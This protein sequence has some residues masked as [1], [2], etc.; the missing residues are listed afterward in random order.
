[1][2]T[3]FDFNENE[4]LNKADVSSSAFDF[5]TNFI[6]CKCEG[7]TEVYPPN[8]G[9]SGYDWCMKCKLPLGSV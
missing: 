5:E 2:K 7:E 6:T 8:L 4:A 9:D 1:M 3:E